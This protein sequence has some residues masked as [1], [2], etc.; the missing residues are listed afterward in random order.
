MKLTGGKLYLRVI[1]GVGVYYA[2][3]APDGERIVG[4]VSDAD[5]AINL[6]FDGKHDVVRS[7]RDNDA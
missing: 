4:Q 2:Y 3:E 7:R 1:H 6:S 5:R